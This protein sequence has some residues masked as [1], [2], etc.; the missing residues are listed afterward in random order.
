MKNKRME[1]KNEWI[2]ISRK[3]GGWKWKKKERKRE[4]KS[5]WN[6]KYR[7]ENWIKM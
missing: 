7:K 5:K 6:D 4:R 1:K 2:K 3:R